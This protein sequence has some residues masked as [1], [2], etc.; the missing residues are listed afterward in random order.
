L[1]D[2]A[3]HFSSSHT[4][5]KVRAAFMLALSQGV[6]NH[7]KLFDSVAK[8]CELVQT[9][10]DILS[11]AEGVSALLHFFSRFGRTPQYGDLDRI[12]GRLL[13]D[14]AL[15][16]IYR[17][18]LL[19]LHAYQLH[20]SGDPTRV[21]AILGEARALARHEGLHG[22]DTRM[23]L[24]ELQAQDISASSAT[25]LSTFSE[26]E[27]HIRCMPAIPRAHFLYVRSIFELGCGNLEQ[28]LK[29][30]EEALPL[31]RTSHWLIGEALALT[32]LAEVYCAAGR[33]EDAARCIRECA[34][35]TE[36]VV[37]PLIEFNLQLV[38][39]ELARIRSSPEFA[40]ALA[41]AFAL[42]REQGYANGF[43]TSSLLLRR[44]IP[45]GVE[46]GIEPSYCRWVI[47]KR[48]FTPP[49]LHRTRWPWPVK[50]RAM[51][52]FRIYLNDEELIVR[53]KG[54]RRPLEVLKLLSAHPNGVEMSRVMDELW[55]DHEGDAARN[56]LD[57]TLHRL[58]KILK[59]KEAVWLTGG[60]LSLNKHIVW[61]DTQALDRI[62]AQQRSWT[63]LHDS[64]EEIL[65]LYRGG[66]LGDEEVRGT[67]LA[68]RDR[69][70]KKFVYC[71]SQ[72]AKGL[73]TSNRW[74][75]VTSLYLRAIDRE[76]L[77]DSLQRGLHRAL[78]VTGSDTLTEA[79][80]HSV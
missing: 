76:P 14:P 37:A 4:E 77:E 43:H 32:G 16:P 57:I 33:N 7:P 54:Q 59:N 41:K 56:A 18:N 72:L 71:I 26:L 40:M 30:G 13:D 12:V 5:V 74:E 78:R 68:A 29:Y 31:I 38:R 11:L 10:Q 8:V 34:V 48:K 25:A 35:I 80:H 65:E 22:E 63:D 75:D 44:L 66:L 2:D 3:P 19:W 23:R 49:S 27:P 42:G 45:Y 36:G 79:E 52:R 64:R 58:R 17:L 6:P 21:V 53:G 39:A 67:L 62:G 51:G 69:F 73:E 60:T 61:L 46:L 55:P 24:C 15:P 20:S 9:E 50:I 1:L 47:A 28:A 70:R